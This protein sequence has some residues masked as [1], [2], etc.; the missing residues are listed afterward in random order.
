MRI[1]G[2]LPTVQA[3]PATTSAKKFRWTG[4]VTDLVELLYALDTCDCI[5]NGEIG[6]EELADALSEIFG[7]EMKNNI[8]FAIGYSSYAKRCVSLQKIGR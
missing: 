3:T 4:K 5:N 6:V 2:L 8:T 7:V 1:K